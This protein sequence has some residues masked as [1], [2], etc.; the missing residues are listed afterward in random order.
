[1][2][3]GREA[4]FIKVLLD[5]WASREERDGMEGE[6][7]FEKMNMSGTEKEKK[8]GEGRMKGGRERKTRKGD[9]GS[10]KENGRAGGQT[11]HVKGS[12]CLTHA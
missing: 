9:Q 11:G 8:S 10:R 5:E 2:T 3:G 1:M 12:L 4:R 7:G 6:R